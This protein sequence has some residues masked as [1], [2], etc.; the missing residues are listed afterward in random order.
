MRRPVCLRLTVCIV[1]AAT[2]AA[3]GVLLA[4]A[5]SADPGPSESVLVHLRSTSS[6]APGVL[7]NAPWLGRKL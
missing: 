5:A 1:T 2:T 4:P 7:S 6:V 3:L